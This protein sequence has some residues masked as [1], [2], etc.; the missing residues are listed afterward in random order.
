MKPNPLLNSAGKWVP[1]VKFNQ[2]DIEQILNRLPGSDFRD[3]LLEAY[4]QS[5]DEAINR[6]QNMEREAGKPISVL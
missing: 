6:N 3:E 4:N 1:G 5:I 2:R